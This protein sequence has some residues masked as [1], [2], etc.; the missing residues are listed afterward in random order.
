MKGYIKAPFINCSVDS[1]DWTGAT[2]QTIYDN[3]TKDVTDGGMDGGIVLMHEYNT[4]T[5]EA[6][7]NILDTFI[8]EGYQVVSVSELFALKGKTLMTGT[9]Y[10]SAN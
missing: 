4:K 9:Q 6:I 7:N 3:V 2:A 1:K 8:D 10:S 5:Y